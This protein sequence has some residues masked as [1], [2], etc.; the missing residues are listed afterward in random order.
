[1]NIDKP[2]IGRSGHNQKTLC[3]IPALERHTA[4]RRHEDRLAVFTVDE[5]RLFLV[6][7][8]TTRTLMSA[9]LSHHPG[10]E[11]QFHPINSR[12]KKT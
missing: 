10:A 8:V 3:V 11:S 4:D 1:M 6:A 12:Q 2:L 9:G 7:A 5:V